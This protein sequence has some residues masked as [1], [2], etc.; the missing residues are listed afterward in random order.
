MESKSRNGICNRR[1]DPLNY[2]NQKR[3]KEDRKVIEKNLLKKL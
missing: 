1:M 2:L 3:F